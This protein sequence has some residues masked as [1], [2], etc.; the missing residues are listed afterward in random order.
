[1]P[2]GSWRD[3]WAGSSGQSA[4]TQ[5]VRGVIAAKAISDNLRYAVA[6]VPDV[7]LFEY[8]VNCHLRPAGG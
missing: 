1:M 3:I 2:S 7:S 4:A 8:E 5:N 6:A